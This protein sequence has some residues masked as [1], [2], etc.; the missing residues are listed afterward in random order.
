MFGRCV[1]LMTGALLL[2]GCVSDGVGT[3]YAAISQK[4]GPP[5]PGQSRI[6]V[7][8]QKREGLSMALCACD[9]K[10][11]GSPIGKPPGQP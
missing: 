8:Q 10:L 5:K 4:V 9:V 1:I 11:D 7:L 6:V 2:T 3:D